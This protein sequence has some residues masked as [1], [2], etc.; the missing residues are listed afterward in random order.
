MSPSSTAYWFTLLGDGRLVT[1]VDVDGAWVADLVLV[2]AKTQAEFRID[3]HV[4]AANLDLEAGAVFGDGVLAY[5]VDDGDR[6]G[7]W[8]ARPRV[9]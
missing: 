1:P 6:S 5:E 8:L 4:F 3:D 2:D 9:D 7:I